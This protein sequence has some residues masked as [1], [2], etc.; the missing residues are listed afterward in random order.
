LD[1]VVSNLSLL[2]EENDEENNGTIFEIG[3]Y[4]K[5]LR[6]SKNGILKMFVE[7]SVLFLFLNYFI[8][9]LFTMRN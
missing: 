4:V 2:D 9:F 3:N 5:K 1:G 7:S 8:S 6:E